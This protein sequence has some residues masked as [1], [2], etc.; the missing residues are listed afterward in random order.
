MLLRIMGYTLYFSMQGSLRLFKNIHV[1]LNFRVVWSSDGKF[2]VILIEH[3]IHFSEVKR[4]KQKKAWFLT[5]WS[6]PHTGRKY[7]IIFW[8]KLAYWERLLLINVIQYINSLGN[9]ESSRS[10]GM[11]RILIWGGGFILQW[12]YYQLCMWMRPHM[13]EHFIWNWKIFSFALRLQ[14]RCF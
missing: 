4:I 7:S 1:S 6:Q 8:R 5:V 10:R 13:Q 2:Q 3:F 14:M 11:H 9:T 12:F